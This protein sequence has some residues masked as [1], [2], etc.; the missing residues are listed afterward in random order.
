MKEFNKQELEAVLKFTNALADKTQGALFA[1]ARTTEADLTEAE[2]EA[3]AYA[4]AR[5]NSKRHH[6]DFGATLEEQSITANVKSWLERR[7]KRGHKV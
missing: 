1:T 4:K 3:K 2:R 5:N 6:S 7:R